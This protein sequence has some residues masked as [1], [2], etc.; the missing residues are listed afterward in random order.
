MRLITCCRSKTAIRAWSGVSAPGRSGFAPG[1]VPD[2]GGH[3]L[4]RLPPGFGNPRGI[5]DEP[6]GRLVFEVAAGIALVGQPLVVGKQG[7]AA[8]G[9]HLHR[10]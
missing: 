1:K 5:A 9:E 6:L 8:G 2:Q 7:E 3:D 4:D 10:H